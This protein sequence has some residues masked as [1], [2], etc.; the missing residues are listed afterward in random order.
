MVTRSSFR[1][2]I[3][4]IIGSL[5]LQNVE[6]E[7][8]IADALV[9]GALSEIL[10]PLNSYTDQISNA[11][12]E[13]KLKGAE[14]ERQNSLTLNKLSNAPVHCQNDVLQHHS[15]V[16]LSWSFDKCVALTDDFVIASNVAWDLGALAINITETAGTIGNNILNCPGWNPLDSVK[17]FNKNLGALKDLVKN[18]KAITQPSFNRALDILKKIRYDFDSC[19][20]IPLPSSLVIEQ[21]LKDCKV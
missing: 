17:C 7:F 19:L 15:T 6:G 11:I 2:L 4:C 10:Q 16:L 14:I 5:F 9:D 21:H 3:L 1:S 18:F 13:M 12:E 8:Q 20:G